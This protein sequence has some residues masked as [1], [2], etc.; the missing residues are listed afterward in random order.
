LTG[1][2][3]HRIRVRYAEVDA[4]GVV[5]NA[6]WLVYFDDALTEFFGWLGYDPT[7]VFTEVLDVALVKAVVEW[8]GPA[9]FDDRMDITVKPARL[10]TSSFDLHFDARIDS[11]A[12]CEATITYVAMDPATHRS[13][14][15]PDEV[16]T[17]L[18]EAQ[19][20]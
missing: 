17:R 20:G 4:Q 5:F 6:N 9:G 15:I 14:P 18:E 2:Y 11:R 13:Q 1:S 10:G 8:R 3:V 12:V 16:R 19:S 7:K